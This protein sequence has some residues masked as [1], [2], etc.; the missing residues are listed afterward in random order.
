MNSPLASLSE[1]GDDEDSMP[2]GTGDW[3]GG[4]NSGK[5]DFAPASWRLRQQAASLPPDPIDAAIERS[6]REMA[7][8]MEQARI[9]SAMERSRMNALS[10]DQNSPWLHAAAG[11]FAPTRTGSFGESMGKGIEGFAGAN[12]KMQAQRLALGEQQAKFGHGIGQE[13]FANKLAVTRLGLEGAKTQALLNRAN[14]LGG[15]DPELIK[16]WNW[17]QGAATPEERQQRQ[18]FFDS[19][20]NTAAV[21]TA[22]A[23]NSGGPDSAETARITNGPLWLKSR[24]MAEEIMPPEAFEGMPLAARETALNNAALNIF[25]AIP[26]GGKP[27]DATYRFKDNS[28]N[29]ISG[30]APEQTAEDIGAAI[31][32][33]KVVRPGAT[34]APAAAVSPPVVAPPMPAP[35]QQAIPPD[36][37]FAK[38]LAPPPSQQLPQGVVPSTAQ[39]SMAKETGKADIDNVN[40]YLEKEVYPGIQVADD[41]RTEAMIMK[42]LMKKN[43]DLTG[44]GSPI[45]TSVGN[46]MAT[47][48]IAPD[49]VKQ[50][51]TNAE[52][53]RSQT[54]LQVLAKQLAQKGVQT[55]SDATRML[56][57]GPDLSKPADANRFLV[58]LMEATSDRLYERSKF[59][60]AYRKANGGNVTG[61]VDA[62]GRYNSDNPMT[63]VVDGKLH[64]RKL[65]E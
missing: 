50:F 51:T 37:P 3:P 33:N 1:D 16:M 23:I 35:A 59:F 27:Q 42:D 62:W 61:A 41:T 17:V 40:K 57:A 7:A 32:G 48:G 45:F 28:G 22:G 2:T 20:Y 47:L 30:T 19:R 52:L 6:N 36:S 63:K 4:L 8:A 53:F 26:K 44:A 15:Q 46:W 65:P 9:S 34:Q 56:Q 10:V 13:E 29:E 5:I 64:F 43:P 18:R 38:Y 60:D 39:K 14:K 49:R 54:L 58:R 55:E 24:K 21:K 25:N 31:N 12:D 11:F